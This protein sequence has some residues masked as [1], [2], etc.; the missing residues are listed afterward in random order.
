MTL[1]FYVRDRRATIMD[2]CIHAIVFFSRKNGWKLMTA[3]KRRQGIP[4]GA[5]ATL[6][7]MTHGI[8]DILVSDRGCLRSA[9]PLSHRIGMD[10]LNTGRN[11]AC[12]EPDPVDRPALNAG[13]PMSRQN[14]GQGL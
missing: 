11:L 9:M 2:I 14:S 13:F 5:R 12:I 4:Q 6:F 8:G 10:H 1:P 3:E 7:R